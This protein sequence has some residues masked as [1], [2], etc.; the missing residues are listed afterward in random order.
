MK[1]SKSLRLSKTIY[2]LT[3]KNNKKKKIFFSQCSVEEL[4]KTKHGRVTF[5]LLYFVMLCKS[6]PILNSFSDC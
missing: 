3:K 6:K 4:K 1:K 2:T 5:R